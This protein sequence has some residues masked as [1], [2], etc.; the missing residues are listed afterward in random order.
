MIKVDNLFKNYGELEVLKGV[1]TH[2]MKGEVVAV[3]GPSG[4]GKSTFLRCINRLEEPTLGHIYIS[5]EDIM[6]PKTNINDQ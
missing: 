3:I 5:G 2:I 6:S 1:S 4:S